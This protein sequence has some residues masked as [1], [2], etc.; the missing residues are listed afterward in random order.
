MH[1]PHLL[2]ELSEKSHKE[3][4]TPSSTPPPPPPPITP[5]IE[6]P[7]P[8]DELSVSLR[9]AWNSADTD[10][11]QSKAD[12]LLQKTE[13]GITNAMAAEAK[14][15]VVVGAVKTGINV[16]GGLEDIEKG[17][18]TLMEGMPVLMSA[19]DEVAKLHPFI[20][21]AVMAFKA[22]WALEMKRRQNDQKIL[23]LHV[24]MKDMMG[25]LIQLKF[26]K[27]AD[28]PAPDG[29]TIKG[30]MQVII[31]NTAKD[32]KA[33]ANACD[34][35][36]KKKLIVKVLKGPIWEG[37]LAAFAGTFTK[38]RSEFEFAMSIHTAL[39]VDAANHVIG[40]VD[41]TT[42]AINQKMDLMMKIFSHIMSPEE[43]EMSR[44][45]DQKGGLACLDNDK[46]LKELNDLENKSFG[47]HR[48]NG[49]K[50]G[51][52]GGDLDDLKD[53]LHANPDQ[54]IAANMEQF[55][56]KFAVQQRQIIDELSRVVERQ[57]DRIIGAVLA[58]P[59]D[60]II[61]PNVHAVWKE[62]GWKGS[63]KTRHLVMALRDHFQEDRKNH[64]SANNDEESIPLLAAEDEW[65]LEYIDVVHLQAISE[66]FDGDASGFVTVAEVNAF[67]MARPL[68]WSL[69]RWIAYWSLGHYQAMQDYG[70]RIYKLFDKLF[71]ILP[72]LLPANKSGA[73]D[74]LST[75]Y[76]GLH[77]VV[78]SLN[79]IDI[80]YRLQERFKSY[81]ASEEERIKGNLEAVKYD[82]D[83]S[84]TFELVMG[85]GRLE[86]YLL[87]T[88]YLLLEKHLQIFRV[89]QN[90]VIHPDELW[91]A[92]D[93]VRRLL[94]AVR[95]R[96]DLLKSIFKQQKFDV[97]QQFN[98]FSGG[99]YAYMND[100]ELLW[101]AKIVQD[102]E[103]DDY[104][105]EESS[106]SP[107]PPL[108]EILNYPV[109]ADNLDDIVYSAPP[110]EVMDEPQTDLLPGLVQLFSQRW[111]GFL[112][113]SASVKYPA[114]TMISLTFVPTSHDNRVQG[115]AASDRV[116]RYDFKVVG[117]CHTENI[118]NI[119]TFQRTFSSRLPA[120]YFNGS[121]NAETSTLKGTFGFEEDISTHFGVFVFKQAAP[122][123]VC[124]MPAPAEL[125][126]QAMEGDNTSGES[127][128]PRA[129]WS[130]AISAVL[131]QVQRDR[132]SWSFFKERRNNRKRFI[133]LYIRSQ[134]GSN[135]FGRNLSNEE[136]EELW[137]LKKSFTNHDS[138]F[139]YSLAEMQIRAMTNHGTHCDNCGGIIGGARL[140]CLVCQ[141][142]DTWNTVDFDDSPSC[143]AARVNR[144]DMQKPHLP[145]H[146]LIKL[147]RVLHARDFGK[148]FRNAKAALETARGIFKAAGFQTTDN[149][150]PV[151]T[152]NGQGPKC[153]NCAKRL[154][155]PCWF[156]V[157][158]TEETFIC[159][160]CDGKGE[161]HISSL[162]ER[163]HDFLAH[164]LVRVQ[165]AVE[166]KALT[167][168]E[169]I[170]VL[171]KAHEKMVE[172]R[173]T[174]IEK[175][176]EVRMTQVEER[177]AEQ[178]AR[179][180]RLLEQLV[181]NTSR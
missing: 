101:A 166:D 24:E 47:A 79:Y 118:G 5:P 172:A 49:S 50:L 22:V 103:F 106:E 157:Q 93:T 127:T 140:S 45:V 44:L 43:K 89:C 134:E 178:M 169:R 145:H 96:T 156:C 31:E 162:R 149:S 144:D 36:I 34:T 174:Q 121:W 28:A 170:G 147:R 120:Q 146:D 113:T 38:R 165:A 56:R 66:A 143:I 72:R 150:E 99:L 6:L 75:A 131:F 112:Y 115:F 85:E 15:I 173:L 19:L 46:A 83:A 104:T 73:N 4:S 74:Y 23:A 171:F 152:P 62:M 126:P 14:A 161:S 137:R 124:F 107:L 60:R 2:K 32:I 176:V 130:F 10:P 67:T 117:E 48:A 86:K 123:Y 98:S 42:Q 26:V 97:S 51:S 78:K 90:H 154:T 82:I 17:I 61:D 77:T 35:Y 57:G 55:S 139:Y 138:R 167:V 168:E 119:I 70:H 151:S 53:E 164:D 133:E 58:G 65:T 52:N 181:A 25:V 136:R 80:N 102:T 135:T 180:E 71:A 132:W 122:E 59:G 95:D 109:D 179:V 29:S 177:M 8:H 30:R 7:I 21:V 88:I 129:L 125:E 92:T 94:S 64:H 3:R 63:V 18:H 108:E 69:P 105:F 13:N 110:V 141:M 111:H 100:E 37:K 160:E 11:K 155:M 54:A 84:D 142:K 12:K 9:D 68:D 27:D 116:N 16:V 33:C 20:G 128:K 114:S 40:L 148:S 39:G 91:D 81:V 76:R 159:W 163:G 1:L 175:T 158:C 153:A 87:P 41:E